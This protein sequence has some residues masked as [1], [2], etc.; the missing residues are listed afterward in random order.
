[1][2]QRDHWEKTFRAN[3]EMY[4]SEP[5]E[6]GRYA[7]TRF[8][9]EGLTRVVELGAGQGRDTLGMLAAG[10][11][12]TAVDYAARPLDGIVATASSPG[13]DLASSLVTVVHDVRQ[14]L[15]F[16]D[17]SFDACYSH[18]LFTM[19]LSSDELVA[20]A[21][22]VR[23]VLRPGGSLYLHRPPRWRR[24]LRRGARPRG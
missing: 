6:P 14:P 21:N 24:P 15:G 20:L 18:M 3:R 23:R 8:A 1:M 5:S 13:V 12:V 22:D 10:L 9:S 2:S 19:A 7:A 4:G 17:A 16:P 11:A